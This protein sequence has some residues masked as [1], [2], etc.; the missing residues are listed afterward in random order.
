VLLGPVVKIVG[1]PN[2]G[3]VGTKQKYFLRPTNVNESP[4]V[5]YPIRFDHLDPT[6]F[7]GTKK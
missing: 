1:L 4:C 2:L 5:V 6:N 3:E 7:G